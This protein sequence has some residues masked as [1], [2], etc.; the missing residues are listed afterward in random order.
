MKKLGCITLVA[1][2]SLPAFGQATRDRNLAATR[3]HGATTTV[4]PG[5][6]SGGQNGQKDTRSQLDKL[7]RQTANTVIQPA[8]KSPKVQPYKLPPEP[9]PAA[10]NFY[11][12]SMPS[13][14]G[15]KNTPGSGSP[16]RSS[17]SNRVNLHGR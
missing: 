6:M 8:E 1:A 4:L 15:V 5:Q 16:N 13:K 17:R 7:E 2:L 9:K 3:K 12:Q 14:T 10:D 11:Q